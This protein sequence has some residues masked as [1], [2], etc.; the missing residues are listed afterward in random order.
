MP[1]NLTHYAPIT[2][3][4]SAKDTDTN[5]RIEDGVS[6]LG[7]RAGPEVLEY[8]FPHNKISRSPSPVALAFAVWQDRT[9]SRP[10]GLGNAMH[11][12]QPGG[13]HLCNRLSSRDIKS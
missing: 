5:R 6:L 10:I 7:R 12:K 11:T 1:V 4:R 9:G 13:Y 2:R 3:L 8:H